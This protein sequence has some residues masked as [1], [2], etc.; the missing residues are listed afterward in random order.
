MKRVILYLSVIFVL[1][2]Y[3][4]N[5]NGRPMLKRKHPLHEFTASHQRFD[6]MTVAKKGFGAKTLKKAMGVE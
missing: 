4:S 2:S 5:T 3:F 6:L 1:I